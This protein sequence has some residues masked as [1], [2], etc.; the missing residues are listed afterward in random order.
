MPPE[1]LVALDSLC[2]DLAESLAVVFEMYF[3]GEADSQEEGTAKTRIHN[4]AEV[5]WIHRR[6][7]RYLHTYDSFRTSL[8]ERKT[9]LG[10]RFW[11]DGRRRRTLSTEMDI[12]DRL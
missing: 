8:P 10:V 9:R 7:C 2:L 11:T 6:L 12:R 5:L 4:R 3:S 1:S